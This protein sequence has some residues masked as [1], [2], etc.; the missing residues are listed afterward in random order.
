[1]GSVK[2]VNHDVI[3]HVLYH[4]WFPSPCSKHHKCDIN[5]TLTIQSKTVLIYL[6]IKY[7]KIPLKSEI[8]GK[9][10]VFRRV[11]PSVLFVSSPW[12]CHISFR[13][14]D[15]RKEMG[16]EGPKETRPSL[17]FM[18]TLRER[19]EGK[20]RELGPIFFLSAICAVVRCGTHNQKA[21]ETALVS[22]DLPSSNF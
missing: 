5:G 18:W 19:M 8:R 14:D 10:F 6:F 21:F 11:H 2:Q 9:V 12:N 3:I 17:L 7:R 22:P 15:E 20:S 4:E 16:P 13:K 1:M